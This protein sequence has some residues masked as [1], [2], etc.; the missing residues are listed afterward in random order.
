MSTLKTHNLQSSDSGSVNIALTSNAGMVVT[1]ITTISNHFFLQKDGAYIDFK[2]T[3]GTQT[4]YIQSRTTDF[5]FNSYGARPVTFGTNDVERVRITSDGDVGV[6]TATPIISSGYGNL[7]LVGSNGGQ[8]E[9]KRLSGDVRHYI[10]GETNLNIGAGYINGGSTSLR[11]LINGNNE[12]MRINSSGLVGIG[13]D[14]PTSNLQVNHATNECT[15]SLFNGGSK[16]AALQAQNSFGTILYSYDSEP[17]MFSV[18]SGVSYS[19]KLEIDSTGNMGLGLTPAYSGLFGGAQRTFQIGGTTAP[20]L[21][22]TSSTSGQADLVLHAGNS[23]RR[24]DIANLT[25]NGSMSIWTKPSSGSIAER[26]KISPDGYVTKSAQPSFAAYRNQQA[27][28]ISDGDKMVF[29]TN[30]H[31]IGN[32]YDTSNGRFTAPIAGSYQLNFY[33][34]LQGNYSNAYLQTKINGNRIFGGDIHWSHNQGSVWHTETYSQ[35]VYLNVND[36]VEL[37]SYTGNGSGSVAWHGNNWGSWSGYL[38]G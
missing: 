19:K 36:Y 32:H 25:A 33:S 5:R 6:G 1:G 8:V 14:N 29:N 30:R 34:I 9:L 10:W 35:V 2:Q 16:K 18:S 27:W 13:T 28:N 4:G 24:V 17:L 7:S 31:N 38:L 26:I 20:C 15:I 21:R 22:I 3:D 12:R 37:Y 11:F 23:G